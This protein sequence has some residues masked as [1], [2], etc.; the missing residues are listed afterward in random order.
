[1][2]LVLFFFLRPLEPTYV[3]HPDDDRNIEERE[4]SYA[5]DLE[6]IYQPY[7]VSTYWQRFK[8]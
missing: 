8:S 3:S 6:T 5:M 4:K 1:M 2:L 7:G